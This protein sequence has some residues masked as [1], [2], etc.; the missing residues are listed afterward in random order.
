MNETHEVEVKTTGN[1]REETRTDNGEYFEVDYTGTYPEGTKITEELKA[2]NH[3]AVRTAAVDRGL[4]PTGE[5]TCTVKRV[6]ERNVRLVYKLPVELNTDDR[7][8]NV[9]VAP[10]PDDTAAEVPTDK[11]S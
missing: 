2:Q 10:Q 4:I 11:E 6:D 8:V 3:N 1:L 9:A 5:P 7:A